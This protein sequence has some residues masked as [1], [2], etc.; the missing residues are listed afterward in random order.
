[1]RG[2]GSI[3]EIEEM[4]FFLRSL[5]IL[6]HFMRRPELSHFFRR[7]VPKGWP[8]WVFWMPNRLLIPNKKLLWIWLSYCVKF[9]WIS[10]EKCVFFEKNE[11]LLYET[12]LD[13]SLHTPKHGTSRIV[14][15]G[16]LIAQEMYDEG[17]ATKKYIKLY[18][19]WK[20]SIFSWYFSNPLY[21]KMLKNACFGA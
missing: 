12:W 2:K 14:L 11:F 3:S 13:I 17:L 8:F 4:F 15:Y 16:I 19:L 9:Q 21:T 6:W 1:M 18:L 10:F 20:K 5:L 7:L